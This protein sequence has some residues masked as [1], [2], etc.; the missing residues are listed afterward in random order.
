MSKGILFKKLYSIIKSNIIDDV[1]KELK[2][3]I[4]EDSN[5]DV[6]EDINIIFRQN[7]LDIPREF[8][9]SKYPTLV[10]YAKL[11]GLEVE[12]LTI[13]SQPIT[14]AFE[15]MRKA[16]KRNLMI[17]EKKKPKKVQ[18]KKKNQKVKSRK[19]LKSK[20]VSK[21][22]PKSE[23]GDNGSDSDSDNG[24]DSD[25]GSDTEQEEKTE[26]P[27]TP[28]KAKVFESDE[29]TK[30]QPEAQDYPTIPDMKPESKS[31]HFKP[32][33]SFKPKPKPRPYKKVMNF[34]EW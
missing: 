18:R 33:S 3:R 34:I 10:E 4:K 16:I 13:R 2:E 30:P 6:D 31:S 32:I 19:T 7:L 8:E 27:T 9:I 22:N 1:T 11:K 20:E 26:T 21:E 28:I 17:P 15:Q 5:T 25:S 23:H 14:K 12:T 29:L 24:S